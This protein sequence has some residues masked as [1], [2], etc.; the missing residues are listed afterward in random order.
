MII[1]Y[2][3]IGF[4]GA[5]GAIARAV[6]GSL[7]PSQLLGMPIQIIAVNIIGSGIMGFLTEVMAL[8][9]SP[10]DGVRYFLL[11][12]FLGGFTTFSSFALE[13]GLLVE[14][15]EILLSILYVTLSVAFSLGAFFLGMR[16]VRLF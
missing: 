1:H 6:V 2:L 16:V 3:W 8:Y 15:N 13:T 11:A 12:G 5:L 10:P 9:W 7:L 14:R 4:G